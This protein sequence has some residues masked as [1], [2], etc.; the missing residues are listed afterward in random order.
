M[1]PYFVTTQKVKSGRRSSKNKPGTSI[2]WK[3]T[4]NGPRYLVY[5][6]LCDLKKLTCP[7]ARVLKVHQN[8][9]LVLDHVHG[10]KYE[11]VPRS[12][13]LMEENV[14]LVHTHAHTLFHDLVLTFAHILVKILSWIK[15]VRGKISI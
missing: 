14:N 7:T 8:Y 13:H 10:Q 3:T 2:F 1:G 6:S 12:V 4:P 9:E 15:W 11:L 5:N